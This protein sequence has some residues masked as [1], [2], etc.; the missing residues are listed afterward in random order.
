[1]NIVKMSLLKPEEKQFAYVCIHTHTHIYPQTI[2]FDLWKSF[3]MLHNGI[4]YKI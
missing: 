2:S 3:W 1:M 4:Y